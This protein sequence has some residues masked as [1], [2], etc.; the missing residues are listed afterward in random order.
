MDTALDHITSGVA[1]AEVSMRVYGPADILPE[2]I[3]QLLWPGGVDPRIVCAP[4][5]CASYPM[6]VS[7]KTS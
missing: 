6:I 3:C 4:M 7:G 1:N 2:I 5:A